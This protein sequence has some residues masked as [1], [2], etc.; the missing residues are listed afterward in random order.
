M[1]DLDAA[2]DGKSS[3]WRYIAGTFSILFIWLILGGIATA[4]LMKDLA[5]G[6]EPASNLRCRWS[7][8]PPLQLISCPLLSWQ[9]SS[10]DTTWNIAGRQQQKIKK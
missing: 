6:E 9:P 5:V 4:F 3:G 1:G 7:A 2:K 8:V 10:D